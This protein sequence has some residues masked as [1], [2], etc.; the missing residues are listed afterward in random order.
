MSV[1][2]LA[3]LS[4]V[5]CVLAALCVLA[6][7]GPARAAEAPSDGACASAR[8]A[9]TRVSTSIALQHDERTYSRI[10]TELTVQ[11]PRPWPLA[12][13]L[14][15]SEDS[16][17]Y[18]RALSCLVPS[19]PQDHR[20]DRLQGR[21]SEWPTG[22]PVVTSKGDRLKVVYRAHSWVNEYRSF[23]E[24]G[25][26]RV[27][28]GAERWSVR[29]R[30]P[31]AL[32][33]A[34]WDSV[35]V[36]P[37]APGSES[38]TPGHRQGKGTTALV[39]RP[40]EA[41]TAGVG[42][43]VER[44]RTGSLAALRAG[45][46]GAAASAAIPAPLAEALSGS[47]RSGM[48][49]KAV[50]TPSAPVVAVELRPSW[51]RS[52]AA[53]SDRLIALGLNHVGGL[54]WDATM[55]ALLM[56][57]ALRHHRRPRLTTGRQRGTLRNLVLWA[58]IAAALPVLTAT[59]DLLT[60]YEERRGDG[61]WFDELVAQNHA[62]ALTTAALLFAFARPT[63]RIWAAAGVLAV[64][65]VVT[66]A[67]PEAFG[68]RPERNAWRYYASDP[69]LIAQTSAA[70]CVMALT[71]LGFAAVAWRLAADGGLFP[72]NRSHPGHDR[73][74]RLRV[75]GP[76][77]VV[78]TLVIAVCYA[79]AEERNWQ[80]ANRLSAPLAPEYGWQHRLDFLWE[81][82][83][84]V[85]GGQGWILAY[86]W[87]LTSVAALAVLRTWRSPS[88]LSPF[89]DEADRLLLLVFFPLA[90][91]LGGGY[92][93]A[94]ALPEVL[95]IPLHMLALYGAVTLFRSRSVL[96]QPFEASQRAFA[97][98]A[99]SGARETLL[100]R[101]RSYREIHAVL[102]RLDQGLF[103]GDQPPEREELEERLSKLHDWPASGTSAPDRLPARASVVDLALA[104][105][106]RDDWWDNGSR[107]ARLALIPGVPAAVLGT[108]AWTVRGEA[109]QDTLWYQ[110]GLPDMVLTFVFWL[111]TC[112][113]AGFVLGALWREL[114]GRRGPAKAVPV[115]L[116]FALPVAFDALAGWLTDEGAAN[117]A[118]HASV[119]LF[120]LT[121]TGIALDL[122]T[123]QGE[124]RYWQSRLGLLLSVYQ[125]RYYSLQVAYLI[126][127]VLAMIAIWEFFAEPSA[128]PGP[129][130]PP[131]QS[132]SQG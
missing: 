119:M 71:L 128:A 115:A 31:P 82:M 65:P 68:L 126:A 46:L 9:G 10:V 52:W 8:L 103:A 22:R 14:L 132:G 56:V 26:W 38:A 13:D 7:S 112:A 47:A 74:L 76:A 129:S 5:S 75:A 62:F 58:G 25:L 73:V 123:F 11:V 89:D 40:W 81:G 53:Q 114:P 15:L 97:T 17:R 6:A 48:G 34:R 77:V 117:M 92:H 95:W 93:L 94:D 1:S 41:A 28:A 85:P 109:W 37:G 50:K 27:R 72:E 64:P 42:R 90:V 131:S 127:Q 83:W 105:G 121:V 116:A 96:A 100:D 29:L 36:D 20:D 18:I 44:A 110:L 59:N 91:G 51:Q 60:Q 30:V 32:G 55:S 45:A 106:P 79:L 4:A 19:E 87:M 57:A 24:V 118:L 49:R 67:W 99:G 3:A 39:W 78:A 70:C 16:P 43:D 12:E 69:A 21:W 122:E 108:W 125:M 107:G 101:A 120:V 86:T 66:M 84:S 2:V 98:V 113:G 35:T 102:R 54:L 130:D 104:L 23:M 111:T 80:R 61:H 33:G 124:R 63:R 88:A